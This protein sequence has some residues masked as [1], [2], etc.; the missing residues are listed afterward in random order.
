MK[1]IENENPG[2]ETLYSMNGVVSKITKR[3]DGYYDILVL[4]IHLES[5]FLKQY[6]IL[7]VEELFTDMNIGDILFFVYDDDEYKKVHLLAVKT[8]YS[9]KYCQHY[10]PFVEYDCVRNRFIKDKKKFK[11]HDSVISDKQKI[12]SMIGWLKSDPAC[13][14]IK[15]IGTKYDLSSSFIS[16]FVF[17]LLLDE[18]SDSFDVKI[19]KITNED[20]IFISSLYNELTDEIIL[21]DDVINGLPMNY[22]TLLLNMIQIFY[23]YYKSNKKKDY[24]IPFV[25]YNNVLRIKSINELLKLL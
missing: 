9:E 3:E 19:S 22:N 2:I 15:V 8:N 13:F 10:N 17:S 23:K 6:E 7:R 5:Q 24:E 1:L 20:I 21:R 16:D 14:G 11:E 25:K 18:Y 4:N 12:D